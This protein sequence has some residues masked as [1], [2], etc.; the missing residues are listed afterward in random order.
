MKK[1]QK[2]TDQELQQ[3][4]A[5]GTS[6]ADLVN[7]FGPEAAEQIMKAL[8]ASNGSNGSGTQNTNTAP[9]GPTFNNSPNSGSIVINSKDS[10]GNVNNNG[11]L[12]GNQTITINM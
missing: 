12:A 1:L 10:R 2:L 6:W 9:A 7:Q 3:I 8:G 11:N 5:A 4:A